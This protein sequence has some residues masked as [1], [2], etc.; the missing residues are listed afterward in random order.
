[1]LYNRKKNI[2]HYSTVNYTRLFFFSNWTYML[3]S[4][5]EIIAECFASKT[6]VL[7]K[8][9]AM[10]KLI[11]MLILSAFSMGTFA[12]DTVKQDTVK[13]Q[14]THKTTSKKTTHNPA[15]KSKVKKSTSK[16]DTIIRDSVIRDTMRTN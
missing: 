3:I 10:K 9:K 13:R 4:K 1:M 15:K 7:F 12:Q 11:I 8:I 6:I 5:T 2:N 14:K 16:T